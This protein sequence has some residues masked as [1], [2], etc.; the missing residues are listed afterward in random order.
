MKP[1]P[2]QIV[3]AIVF[4]L[5]IIVWAS[6][7]GAHDSHY[8]LSKDMKTWFDGL[9]SG[10]GPCCSDADGNV[11]QDVDWESN[12][13]GYRVR[14]DG[15]WF[16]VPADAVVNEPNRYGPTMVWPLRTGAWNYDTGTMNGPVSSIRCFMPGSMG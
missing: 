16:D 6:G 2:F 11:I 9:K 15:K 10:Q 13:T 7:V 8:A 14:I 1:S 5:I 12:G 3:M 4:L